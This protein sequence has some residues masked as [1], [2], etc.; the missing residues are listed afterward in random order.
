MQLYKTHNYNEESFYFLADSLLTAWDSSGIFCG[1]PFDSS[2]FTRFD[3]GS[4]AAKRL[5]FVFFP[6]LCLAEF[7]YLVGDLTQDCLMG[8][9]ST[10][11]T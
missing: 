1:F 9:N 11:I 3:P 4:F 6:L 7:P 5:S 8:D 10:C 2:V